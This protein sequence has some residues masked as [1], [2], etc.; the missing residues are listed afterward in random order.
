MATS[1][2]VTSVEVLD[3]IVSNVGVYRNIF[4]ELLHALVYDRGI[5]QN[6]HTLKN[7]YGM[8]N[9]DFLFE[10]PIDRSEFKE[11]TSIIFKYQKNEAS[12]WLFSPPPQK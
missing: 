10:T 11:L 1:A 12:G 5:A 8:R 3:T 6:V 2:N 4:G 9:A 7:I